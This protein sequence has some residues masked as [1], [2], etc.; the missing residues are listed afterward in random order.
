MQFFIGTENVKAFTFIPLLPPISM[1][2]VSE[3][4]TLL[5]SSETTLSNWASFF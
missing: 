5:Q 3:T 2:S 1:C 4:Q